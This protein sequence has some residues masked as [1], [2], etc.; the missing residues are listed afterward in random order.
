MKVRTRFAP[1]PT[2]TIHLGS[3][4]QILFDYAYAKKNRGD[5]IVRV[6]D[7][8]QK[9]Y[10]KEAEERVY[11]GLSWLK[12]I[13][14]EGPV[15]GGDYGPYR[16]SE[17]LPVYKKYAEEL[18]KNG[19]AY[20]CFCSEERLEE[21]RKSCRKEKKAPK[22]DR[23]CRDVPLSEAM[24]KIAAGQ[25]ATI[26]MIIPDDE[27]VICHDLV[28]G[29]IVF[30]SNNLD[31][32]V[33]LKSDGFPTYHLASTV[34][35]HLMKITHVVRGQEWLPSF[36]KHVLL[37]RYFDWQPPIFFHTPVILD[38]EGGKL[39]KR[40][41]H[42][43]L[44]WYKENGFLRDALLNFLSLLGWSHPEEKEIFSLEEFISL[45]DLKDV[46]PVAPIFDIKKLEWMNGEYIRAKTNS[47]LV[48]LL[49]P[50]LPE[51]NEKQLIIAAPLIK[52]R[53]KT[54]KE[55]RNLLEF[56]WAYPDCPRELLL[57][58]VNDC[59][60][61]REMLVAAKEIIKELGIDETIK[62]QESMLTI[63]KE[64]S[65]STGCFFMVLRVAICVKPIT[66]PILESLPLIG[67]EEALIRISKAMDKLS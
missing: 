8:D 55:A 35:D 46:S 7:T 6:E 58:K 10:T 36:P 24:K 54:L 26:R 1:S 60:I 38:P 43:S 22:Y 4:Y 28:R 25:K 20:Y 13:P 23:S 49:K 64:K 53:I 66:P 29:E 32:Q 51:L 44:F 57:Q 39:S 52:E 5:F 17:R 27:K 16:Q 65:W 15:T 3:V 63:I 59:R 2:G 14:D 41:G 21:V 37:Y 31:D 19:F 48:G 56:I 34:D 42:T 62:L 67:K 30:E 50:F 9:R 47:E 45:F 11:E 12:I 18:V 61:A 33:I 40:K